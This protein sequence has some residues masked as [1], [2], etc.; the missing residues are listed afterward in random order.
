[1]YVAVSGASTILGMFVDSAT[2]VSARG[3]I[4]S[5]VN[6]KSSFGSISE[7]KLPAANPD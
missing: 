1:M 4:D 3:L 7:M 5:Y 6:I 2:D